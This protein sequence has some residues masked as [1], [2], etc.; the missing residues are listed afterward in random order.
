MKHAFK[1]FFAVF[2]FTSAASAI[3]ITILQPNY[4]CQSKEFIPDNNLYVTVLQDRVS[5][6]NHLELSQTWIGGVRTSYFEV[7]EKAEKNGNNQPVIF[8]GSGVK[9]A[10]EHVT[11]TAE[12]H[13]LPAILSIPVG[14]GEIRTEPLICESLL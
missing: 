5:G 9:L 13:P 6:L 7:S 2:C 1:I 8:E 4:R 11:T 14:G 12:Q 3:E 10:I